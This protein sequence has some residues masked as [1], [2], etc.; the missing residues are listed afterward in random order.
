MSPRATSPRTTMGVAT[1]EHVLREAQDAKSTV[2]WDTFV[3]LQNQ[4]Q[5]DRLR[6]FTTSPRG[7]SLLSPRARSPRASAQGMLVPLT[8]RPA[9]PYPAEMKVPAPA[10]KPPARKPVAPSPRGGKKTPRGAKAGKGAKAGPG[11]DPAAPADGSAGG[12]DAAAAAA[13]K[14]AV[15]V[16][17]ARL[18]DKLVQGVENA[19]NQRFSDMRKA[20]QYIDVNNDGKVTKDELK[21]AVH[22]WNVSN[23]SG[24]DMDEVVERVISACDHNADGEMDYKEFINCL[25][26]DK[27]VGAQP[28]TQTFK[29]K[30]QTGD[31]LADPLAKLRDGVTPEELV[32]AHSTVRDRLL[33]RY[34]TILKAFKFMDK[35]GSGY[36]TR[37]EF[38]DA[39][40]KLNITGISKACLDTLLDIIDIEDNDDGGDD[41]DIGFREFA[42][43]MGAADVFK[44]RALAPRPD[45]KKA[46]ANEN[47]RM[48]A[49]GHLRLGVTQEEMR[50]AQTTIKEKISAKHGKHAFTNAFKWMDK[51]RTGSITR[52]EFKQALYELNLGMAIRDDIINNLCDFI[53]VDKSGSFGYREFARVLAAD[54]VMAMAPSLDN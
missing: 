37:S 38:E 12:A 46:V 1:P 44:M 48:E 19:L 41:H 5:S 54:D 17:D 50:K 15:S 34:D 47:L 21:R 8:P 4:R 20:F 36:I 35:D 22:F 6:S 45:S 9:I 29:I 49:L 2:F 24:V 31:P 51:D 25:A 10:P 39:M 52:E 23:P 43:V 27:F 3:S 11:G 26:R 16:R 42:R 28:Q 40:R 13:A 53:D 14:A 33:D 32:R 30:R 7:T 18:T